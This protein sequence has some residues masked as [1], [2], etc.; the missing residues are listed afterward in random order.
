MAP[1]GK[2]NK[3]KLYIMMAQHTDNHGN[4]YPWDH[5]YNHYYRKEK[6]MFDSY[7]D[8]AFGNQFAGMFCHAVAVYQSRKKTG[9]RLGLLPSR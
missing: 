9:C 1:S 5:L 7:P 3:E 8:I 2:N 4:V 6:M